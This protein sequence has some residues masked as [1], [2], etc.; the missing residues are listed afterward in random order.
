VSRRERAERAETLAR[1]AERAQHDPQYAAFAVMLAAAA[2]RRPG[3]LWRLS[4]C[5]PG[6]R[7][8]GAR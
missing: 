8:G 7:P 1:I 4:R 6:R 2:G 3:L 5:L